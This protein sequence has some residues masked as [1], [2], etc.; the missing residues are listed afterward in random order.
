[1]IIRRRS[2][3]AGVLGLLGVALLYGGWRAATVPVQPAATKVQAPASIPATAASGEGR[4]GAKTEDFFAEYRLERER[5]RSRQVE[6]L[7]GLADNSRSADETRRKAQEQL[8]EISR[9]MAREVEVEQL[10]RAKGFADAVVS[11]RDGAAT[12]VVKA[13]HLTGE[14]AVRISDLVGRGAGIP[15]RNVFIIPR[16]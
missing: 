15:A 16:E 13:P 5:M 7:E 4:A 6:L 12:V 8:L 11:F 14:E 1:V 2:L 10:L 9:A 3:L